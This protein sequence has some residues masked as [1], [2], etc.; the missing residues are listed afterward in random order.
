MAMGLPSN[1][2]LI[3]KPGSDLQSL[4]GKRFGVMGTN[5]DAYRI[6]RSYLEGRGLDPEADFELVEIKNPANL[7]ASFETGQIE[8][9]VLLSGYAVEAISTGGVVVTTV[10]DAAEEV[11][12]HP[13]YSTT[14]LLGEGFMER[15]KVVDDFLR[16]LRETKEEIMKNPE[17]AIE[18]HAAFAG[19]PAEKMGALFQ[20]IT[21]VCDI[22]DKIK[23]DITAF[24]DY[25]LAQGYFGKTF[26]EEVFYDDWK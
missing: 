24:T 6:T 7:Y 17:E 23:E 15:K 8:A 10:T 11:F 9:A 22:D 1:L 12:G 20:I 3:V 18:I 5:S 26:E 16:A 21:L 19:E 2:M 4:K 13:A 25:G 14:V